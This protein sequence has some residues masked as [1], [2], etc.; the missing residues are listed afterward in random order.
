MVQ[1]F[2]LHMTPPTC[3]HVF[4]KKNRRFSK[5]TKKHENK[6]PQNISLYSIKTMSTKSAPKDLQRLRLKSEDQNAMFLLLI[7]SDEQCEVQ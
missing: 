4:C 7:I 3:I 2:V 5:T 6:M 1:I